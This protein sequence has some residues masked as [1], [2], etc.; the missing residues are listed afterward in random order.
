MKNKKTVRIALTLAAAG[1]ILGG[2]TACSTL[3]P[4]TVQTVGSSVSTVANDSSAIT[5]SVIFDADTPENANRYAQDTLTK[6]N[7]QL[8]SQFKLKNEQFKTT[9]A[10]TGD[11]DGKPELRRVVI[12]TQVIDLTTEQTLPSVDTILNVG[13]M[14]VRL[15]SVTASPS[16]D[17]KEDATDRAFEDAKI[18]AERLAEAS[19]KKLGSVRE[20][21]STDSNAAARNMKVDSSATEFS[22]GTQDVT[23]SI[24]VKWVIR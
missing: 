6:V 17:A 4:A 7:N 20:V 24:T 1:A 18:K 14:N 2:S 23:T 13:G 22:P 8:R 21:V 15:E 16:K 11:V 19:G 12:T 10:N 5:Y 3:E 9:G